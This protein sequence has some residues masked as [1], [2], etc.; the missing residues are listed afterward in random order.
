MT[1]SFILPA[2]NSSSASRCSIGLAG[3]I[4]RGE[5]YSRKQKVGKC[6][7]LCPPPKKVQGLLKMNSPAP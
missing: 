3:I 2:M 7:F 4:Q 5:D 6:V 1:S